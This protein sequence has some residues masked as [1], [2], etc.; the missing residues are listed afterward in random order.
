MPFVTLPLEK[1]PPL[2]LSPQTLCAPSYH[3]K[4]L[5]PLPSLPTE[6]STRCLCRF[7][8]WYTVIFLYFKQDQ[9][10]WFYSVDMRE[11]VVCFKGTQYADY[12]NQKSTHLKAINADKF[13]QC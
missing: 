5:P 4:V 13:L 9:H 12:A 2:F 1:C 7:L 10:C 3:P 11:H 6:W 8:D